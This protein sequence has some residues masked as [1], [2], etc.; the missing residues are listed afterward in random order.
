MGDKPAQ[1]IGEMMGLLQATAVAIVLRS[2]KEIT[3]WHRGA[4]TI[5]EDDYW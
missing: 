3:L 1:S 4:T 2:K 5:G